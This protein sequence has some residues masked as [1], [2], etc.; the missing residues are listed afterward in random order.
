MSLSQLLL[1]IT[2]ILIGI[3]WVGWVDISATVIGIFALIT[4]ALILLEGLGSF[5]YSLPHRRR[6]E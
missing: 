5:S 6:S 2:L 4:G 1:A 3:V